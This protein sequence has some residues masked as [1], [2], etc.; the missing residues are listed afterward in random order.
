MS[1]DETIWIPDNYYQGFLRGCLANE[2]IEETPSKTALENAGCD[3]SALC[4][5][6]TPD[7][8]Q[9]NP[10][11]MKPNEFPT[12]I[13]KLFETRPADAQSYDE[14]EVAEP[15]VKDIE[16]IKE[17]LDTDPHQVCDTCQQ[18]KPLQSFKKFPGRGTKY[19]TTCIECQ[20]MAKEKMPEFKQ[21]TPPV[22]KPDQEIAQEV[23]EEAVIVQ[24][25]PAVSVTLEYLKR[26]ATEA[27]ERGREH[28][29]SNI[30]MIEPS[31]DELLGVGA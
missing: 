21:D 26:I 8:K 9:H 10:R 13:R 15:A 24:T 18:P 2:L 3:I 7:G 1:K 25:R 19:R 23:I 4:Y 28:E 27:F 14:L 17:M 6:I 29:R 12:S 31:L 30:S 22:P 16:E 11:I 5:L 20:T